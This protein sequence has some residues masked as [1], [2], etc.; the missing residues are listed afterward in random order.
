MEFINIFINI[1]EREK[2]KKKEKERE[3]HNRVESE[4]RYVQAFANGVSLGMKIFWI[5]K[6]VQRN[7]REKK[8]AKS[9]LVVIAIYLNT[10]Y[11]NIC[12]FKEY[13]LLW[14][15]NKIKNKMKKNKKIRN[16]IKNINGA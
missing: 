11:F 9:R 12:L 2:E 13:Y 15:K 7:D 10:I 1:N 14:K 3:R 8:Q 6:F 5:N 16:K 4:N